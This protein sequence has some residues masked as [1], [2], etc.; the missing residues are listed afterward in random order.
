MLSMEWI[1]EFLKI[2]VFLDMLIRILESRIP[3]KTT[4]G[5]AQHCI[6]LETCYEHTR[7]PDCWP[8]EKDIPSDHY[9]S[10]TAAEAKKHA[11]AVLDIIVN[12]ITLFNNSTAP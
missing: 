11:E 4:S 3:G 5:L 7:Y 9:S 2:T 6:T 1:E 12:S 10:T 8:T